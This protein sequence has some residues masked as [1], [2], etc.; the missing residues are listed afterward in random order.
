M[1]PSRCYK[2]NLVWEWRRW[3]KQQP[4]CPRCGNLATRSRVGFYGSCYDLRINAMAH[5]ISDEVADV[6]RA[7][8]CS[9]QALVLNGQLDR[10]LYQ[11]VNKVLEISRFKW[12][13]KEKR[14]LAIKGNAAETLARA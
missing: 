5:G 4:P 9:G 3:F 11:S 14:H 1:R 2:C 12:N 10:K 6:L 8:T 13:K 7:A